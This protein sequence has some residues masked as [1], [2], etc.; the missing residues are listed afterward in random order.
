MTDNELTPEEKEMLEMLDAETPSAP[1]QKPTK[2]PK[3]PA[4]KNDNAFSMWHWIQEMIGNNVAEI[5]GDTGSGKT[6]TCQ[7]IAYECTKEG[8]KVYYID[9]EANFSKKDEETLKKVGVTYQLITNKDQLY[10]LDRQNIHDFDLVI[11][12]SATLVITGI[13]G[14]LNMNQRGALLQQLQGLIFRLSQFCIEKKTCTV[15]ITAQPISVMGDRNMIQ[16]IGDKSMFMTKSIYYIR[17]P[18]E[19]DTIRERHLVTFRDRSFPDG[20]LISDIKTKK[21]GADLDYK[22]M[23]DLLKEL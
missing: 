19:G 17:A 4:K 23:Q 5:F 22:R 21:F 16:P 3:A 13:W 11:I 20:T 7:Q 2:P 9:T 1:I 15:I 6:K 8:K 14:K 18:R 12:D 10:G